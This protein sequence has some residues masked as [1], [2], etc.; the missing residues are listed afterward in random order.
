M[1]LRT[2][3]FRK[4][5]RQWYLELPYGR[6]DS[7][8]DQ[9]PAPWF[10][11]H[12]GCWDIHTLRPEYGHRMSMGRVGLGR[13]W[14]GPCACQKL[15]STVLSHITY[16]MGGAV[17]GEGYEGTMYPHF[18]V[19]VAR[20]RNAWKR[21]KYHPER[22]EACRCN[23]RILNFSGFCDLPRPSPMRGVSPPYTT[24][25]AGSFPRPRVS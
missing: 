23:L 16:S 9:P 5:T 19:T 3:Q 10:V 21:R 13:G 25:R 15:C 4:V 2:F 14:S 17:G 1:C 11:R 8:T 20:Q 7:L 6:D 22:T 24:S 18:L 12:T